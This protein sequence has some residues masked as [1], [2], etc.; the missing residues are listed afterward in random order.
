MKSKAMRSIAERLLR[1]SSR[2]STPLL[3]DGG[4]GMVCGPFLEL[5]SRAWRRMSALTGDFNRSM[6]HLSS[7]NRAEEVADEAKTD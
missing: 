5:I 4:F 7:N 6:Q 1:V 2:H 3:S